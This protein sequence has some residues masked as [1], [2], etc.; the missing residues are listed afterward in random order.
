MANENYEHEQE[1][2][3]D[4]QSNYLE[5]DPIYGAD[6]YFGERLDTPSENN[7][8]EDAAMEEANASNEQM[9]TPETASGTSTDASPAEFGEKLTSETDSVFVEEPI[10]ED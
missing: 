4:E 6:T 7:A 5:E 10:D 8:E 9:A 3:L 2:E 1:L